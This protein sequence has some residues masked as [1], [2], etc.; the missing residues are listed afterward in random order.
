MDGDQATRPALHGTFSL[1]FDVAAEPARVF[2]AYADPELR[3]TWFRM[4]AEP[5]TG[6]GRP[7]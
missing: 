7:R 2:A 4:P 6:A 3:R 5:D 1:D